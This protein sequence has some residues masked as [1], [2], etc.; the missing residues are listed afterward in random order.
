MCIMPGVDR[1]LQHLV[2]QAWTSPALDWWAALVGAKDLWVV[3]LVGLFAL[4]L[5]KGRGRCRTAAVLAALVLIVGD[6]TFVR[7]GKRLFPRDRPRDAIAGVR[8]VTLAA[9]SPASGGLQV[10]PL[11]GASRP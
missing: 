5:W 11:V 7:A 9:V 1:D 2:N 4:A 3:V 6:G 8:T 10:A